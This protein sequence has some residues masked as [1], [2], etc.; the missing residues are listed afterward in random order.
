LHVARCRHARAPHHLDFPLTHNLPGWK[1][2]RL[3]AQGGTL[4]KWFSEHLPGWNNPQPTTHNQPSTR[5]PQLATTDLRWSLWQNSLNIP[6]DTKATSGV[7]GLTVLQPKF[8]EQ[9]PSSPTRASTS[10]A[11]DSPSKERSRACGSTRSGPSGRWRRSSSEGTPWPTAGPQPCLHPPHA[12]THKHIDTRCPLRSSQCPPATGCCGGPCRLSP[13]ARV[14]C[15]AWQ[16]RS[17][18]APLR[19]RR[20]RGEDMISTTCAAPALSRPTAAAW[21]Q[22]APSLVQQRAFAD[23]SHD[24]FKPKYSA[25]SPP[26]VDDQIKGAISR[27]KVHLFMKASRSWCTHATRDNSLPRAGRQEMLLPCVPSAGDTRCASVRLQ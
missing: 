5:T 23:D 18:R 22:A 1:P 8:L 12:P 6:W 4:Y 15:D 2:A 19:S 26:S 20:I 7:V 11:A 27:D 17:H 25:G 13:P 14:C 10:R 21:T 16:F 24:D 9:F 3:P